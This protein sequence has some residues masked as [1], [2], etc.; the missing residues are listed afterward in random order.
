MSWYGTVSKVVLSAGVILLCAGCS[1]RKEVAI[2]AKDAEIKNQ[3]DLIEQER[4]EKAKLHDANEQL[5]KQNEQL[6]ER[7]AKAAADNAA[8]VAAMNQRLS[9]LSAIMA[10]M[11]KKMVQVKPGQG[12]PENADSAWSR[13]SDGSIR[14][15]VASTVLFDSGA[16]DLKSSA[17][18][19]LSNVCKTIKARFPNNYIRVEGHTDSTPVV[20]NKHKFAD[21]MALSIA[22]SRAVYDFM[23]K[24]GGITASKMYTA[25][26][27]EF[28]P[29]VHPEKTAADRSKN[30][31]VEIVI[32]PDTVKIT[33]EPLAEAKPAAASSTAKRK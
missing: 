4:A 11:D 19:M 24:S 1:G 26:Y 12:V 13:G 3:R 31:R 14:I 2:A 29:L 30:R 27:G 32:M 21:N 22:R 23:I 17:H 16:A 18:P 10:E 9:D 20:R 7:N 28:Q 6:A 15:T 25:G 8:Q 5:A 33:K